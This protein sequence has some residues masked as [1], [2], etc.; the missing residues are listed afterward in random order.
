M[1]C[2]LSHDPVAKMKTSKGNS[3]AHATIAESVAEASST[4]TSGKPEGVSDL[5][6]ER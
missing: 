2:L 3:D 5:V 4:S 6:V 1:A